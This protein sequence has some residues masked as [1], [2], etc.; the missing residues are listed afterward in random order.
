MCWDFEVL[1]NTFLEF[2]SSK[3]SKIQL[4]SICDLWIHGAK[5]I[6]GARKQSRNQ[7]NFQN[8]K[9]C[10]FMFCDGYWYHIG[11]NPFMYFDRYW[12]HNYDSG[13]FIKRFFGIC[14]CP[15]FPKLTKCW[16][17]K[18]NNTIF[19]NISIC[20]LIFVRVFR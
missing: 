19:Q 2:W 11:K 4:F 3:I 9:K 7:K 6:V 18:C 5:T 16:K 20:L 10:H 8:S 12:F 13:N 1:V 15:S 17:S 14:W